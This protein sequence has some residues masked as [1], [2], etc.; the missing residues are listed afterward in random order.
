MQLR[1]SFTLVYTSGMRAFYKIALSIIGLL[2]INN[3]Y[4]Q[5]GGPPM[6]T[7][8]P[9]TVDA[10][11][12]EINTSINTQIT[13]DV[14]LAVPYVDVNY[15][16]AE[17]LHLKIETPY[18]ITIDHQKHS[19]GKIADPLIG[20]KYRFMNEDKHF[21][22]AGIYPQATI[23]GDQKGFLF[24]LLLA[25]TIGKFVIGEEIGY[26][27]VVKDSNNLLIGTLL[28]YQL[29][30]RLEVMGE[31]FIQKSYTPSITTQGFM[32]CGCRYTINKTFTFLGS[33][34][35]QVI[36]PAAQQKLYFFSYIGIQSSF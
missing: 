2:C 19:S 20:I 28:S 29:S 12:W 10:G 16:I 3:G 11:K 23:T 17:G 6:L 13:N 14:Q 34:G 21:I 8:D 31:I 24:P 4:A 30:P 26:S 33:L 32:N 18:L 15:G 36:T 22:A 35:T 7:D 1:S 9:G 5:G 25:K 27:Y